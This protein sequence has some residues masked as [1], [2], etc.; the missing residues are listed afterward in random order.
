M[1]GDCLDV[2]VIASAIVDSDG[3][4]LLGWAKCYWVFSSRIFSVAVTESE[5]MPSCLLQ[6]SLFLKG[7]V[8]FQFYAVSGSLAQCTGTSEEQTKRSGI[9]LWVDQAREALPHSPKDHRNAQAL[10]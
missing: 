3:V 9:S 2:L 1:V 10:P 7:G 8:F 6:L 4:Q 5:F